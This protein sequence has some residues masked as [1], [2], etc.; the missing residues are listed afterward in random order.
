MHNKHKGKELE[1]TPGDNKQEKG[2]YMHV[3]TRVLGLL[4]AEILVVE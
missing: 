4:I 1:R 3:R 2:T